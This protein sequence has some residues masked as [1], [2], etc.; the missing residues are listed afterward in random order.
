MCCVAECLLTRDG[1]REKGKRA[2]IDAAK[3]CPI[4]NAGL[5]RYESAIRLALPPRETQRIGMRNHRTAMATLSTD[6]APQ[7]ASIRRLKIYSERNTGSGY[8]ERL[9]L[10]NLQ[11]ECLRGGLPR[12]LRKVFPESELVR[13]A[14]FRATRKGNLGWKHAFAPSPTALRDARPAP[15]EILF[16][17][18][19]K[20]PYAWLVSLYRRPYHARRRY[21]SFSQFLSEPWRSVRRENGATSFSNPIE[22]WNQKTASYLNLGDYANRV[23]CRY[24]D[25]L[26]DPLDFLETLC[27]EHGIARRLVPFENIREATKGSDRGKTFED[28]RD[29]YLTERWRDRLEADNLLLINE[30][31]DADLMAR[32]RYARIDPSELR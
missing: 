13:D 30:S 8:L 28:Y 24:E 10:R 15:Q 29:E 1:H 20:N 9:V 25:L 26:A 6:P 12:S 5:D 11:V 16:L 27:R 18:L 31:L 14:F 17:T 19:T 23:L 2:K 4:Q 32:L 7:S 3:S 22:L 21:S